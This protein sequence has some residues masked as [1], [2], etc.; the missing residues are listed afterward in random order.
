[1]RRTFLDAG[2]TRRSLQSRSTPVISHLLPSKLQR[3]TCS[4]KDT[5]MNLDLVMMRPT[6]MHAAF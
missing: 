4:T 2:S 5:H 3:R 1:M 6:C